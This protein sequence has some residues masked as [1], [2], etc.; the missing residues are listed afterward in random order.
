[1]RRLQQVLGSTL[2]FLLAA[3][4]AQA[5]IRERWRLDYKMEGKPRIYT[6]RNAL[7]DLTNY[8]YFTYTVTNKTDQR[9]P[10]LIDVM[11]YVE[12]GKTMLHDVA[13][14]DLIKTKSVFDAPV[15]YTRP[16]EKQLY[17][18]FY[19]STIYPEAEY[20]IIINDL[21]LGN[22]LKDKEL[23]DHV[24]GII[25]G[26]RGIQEES[27]LAFKKAYRYLNPREI[28]Q[29][30]WIQPGESVH[31]I[32]IFTD[33]DARANV[34]EVHISGLWDILKIRKA[35]D[36][37]VELEYENRVLREIYEFP[38]DAFDREMDS[39]LPPP[40]REW[41]IK[42]IGPIASRE[43]IEQ[44]VQT[45]I[46]FLKFETTCRINN[47]TPDQIAQARH[48]AGILDADIHVCA[49][50]FQ[51]AMVRDFG[52]DLDKAPWENR[53]SIWKMH[54]FWLTNKSKFAF[55]TA[56]NQYVIK[57]DILPG[58]IDVQRDR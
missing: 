9:V 7:D 45:M 21:K 10:C 30:Q 6:H 48:D 32:A 46:D 15:P 19:N 41:L 51:Q 28:R 13:K 22:R 58:K 40:K 12:S 25:K 26:N 57:E 39:I 16:Y 47:M 44:L 8:W 50:T 17:G 55:D 36:E 37:D 42:K 29:K 2:L 1:M 5:Q 56:K 53:R 49:R 20:D 43:T 3:G 38:G 24:E 14:V 52:Y 11:L 35:T 4:A 31:G 54:E 18:R 33:V 34:V 27:I 23:N